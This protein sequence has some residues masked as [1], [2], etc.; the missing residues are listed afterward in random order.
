MLQGIK[1]FLGKAKSWK[2]KIHGNVW[3]SPLYKT[4]KK[5]T[6]E[7]SKCNFS[8]PLYAEIL[9]QWHSPLV[10]R[11]GWHTVTALLPSESD[12]DGEVQVEG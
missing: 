3:N 2:S 6:L 5:L 8:E 4:N 9:V 1:V 10:T 12:P 11:L 7:K